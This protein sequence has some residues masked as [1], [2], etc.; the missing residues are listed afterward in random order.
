MDIRKAIQLADKFTRQ[1]D[2]LCLVPGCKNKA[3]GSHAI[4]KS[5]ILEALADKGVVYT[6]PQSFTQM[7]YQLE[8]TEPAIISE[9]G[10]NKASVFKGYCPVHDTKLFKSAES[11]DIS[12]RR[13][14]TTALHCRALSLE[15]CRQ[16][17]TYDFINK[18]SEHVQSKELKSKLKKGA[19]IYFN[20][21]NVFK[22]LNLYRMFD[23][24]EQTEYLVVPFTSNLQ[25]SCCGVF[26]QSHE[27][28]DSSI[29]FNLISFSNMSTLVLTTFKTAERHL[30]DF[31]DFYGIPCRRGQTTTIKSPDFERM[32]NDIA[33]YKGEEPLISPKLW[34]SLSEDDK[35]TIRLALRAPF[36]REN[37]PEIRI[38]KLTSSTPSQGLTAEMLQHLPTDISD[39]VDSINEQIRK[40]ENLKITELTFPSKKI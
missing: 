16:R 23:P 9:V 30:E 5:A 11:L 32:V 36:V 38:I 10:V 4:Q 25:V 20:S 24:T 13:E 1:R 8:A 18:L 33:F 7:I 2:H 28:Y 6:R 39:A 3:I 37:E 17:F 27:D 34:K 29:G 19:A 22:T 12:K 14:M 26:R 21:S 40:S 31:L 35:F 15:Y